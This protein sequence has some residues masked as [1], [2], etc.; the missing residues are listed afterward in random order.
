MIYVCEYFYLGFVV[1]CMELG[2][3]V[4]AVFKG[5]VVCEK[6]EVGDV[7]ILL[8]GKI[9]CDGVGGVIGFFKV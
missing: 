5:N 9:G 6:L 3:V 8:G 4:G 1:K 2:V 7:I